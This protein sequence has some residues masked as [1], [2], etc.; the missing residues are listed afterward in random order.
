MACLVL[1]T[2]SCS[3]YILDP[4]AFTIMD[5]LGLPSPP[6]FL[7]V[8]GLYDV[9]FRIVVAC[10]SGELCVLKRGWQTAKVIT[11]LDS[12]PVGLVR[13]EKNVTVATMDNCLV[14]INN[15]VGHWICVNINY[16][17]IPCQGK[18]LWSVSLPHSVICIERMDIPSRGMFLVAVALSSNH[19][20][21]YND[22]NVV[23]CFK[24]DDA[25]SAMKFGRFGREENT[26]VIGK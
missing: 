18:K 6:V 2:E 1:G 9:E 10:R 15:K 22:K 14:S 12:Q 13:R 3:V 16:L 11:A 24:T 7:S 20:L 26:L 21:V 19:V 17:T 4:E 25:V 8:S 5:S 23:D